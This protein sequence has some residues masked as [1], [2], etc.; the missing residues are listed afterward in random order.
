MTD[1]SG[2]GGS[3]QMNDDMKYGLWWG[4]LWCGYDA[5]KFHQTM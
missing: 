1:G 5:H 2:G 3:Q 4:T